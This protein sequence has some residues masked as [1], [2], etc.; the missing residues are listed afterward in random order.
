[1]IIPGRE[2][3]LMDWRQALCGGVEN[4]D[5]QYRELFRR[6]NNLHV[7]LKQHRCEDEDDEKI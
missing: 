6:I 3:Q 2:Y 1:M 5:E 4:I 7:V